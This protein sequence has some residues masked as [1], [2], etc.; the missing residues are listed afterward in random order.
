[1][2]NKILKNFSGLKILL[3][4]ILIGAITFVLIKIL[5]SSA[6][7][8]VIIAHIN[9]ADSIVIHSDSLVKPVLYSKVPDLSELSVKDRKRRF[10]HL[11]L[12]AVLLAQEKMA[13]ERAHVESLLKKKKEQRFSLKTALK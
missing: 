2:L 11:M 9:A 8:P 1:M 10:I 4:L 7:S 3:V 12:P 6:G 5:E 13:V